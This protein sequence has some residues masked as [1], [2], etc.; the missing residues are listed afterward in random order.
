M[1]HSIIT[2]LKHAEQGCWFDFCFRNY[3][4]L[5]RHTLVLSS[6]SWA[7]KLMTW[8]LTRQ[9]SKSLVERA[10]CGVQGLQ[11]ESIWWAAVS[12][13]LL[14]SN[15]FLLQCKFP[16]CSPSFSW[17][18][19]P[20]LSTATAPITF[21]LW[22]CGKTWIRWGPKGI[23][24]S[25]SAL[26]VEQSWVSNVQ[27]S[28][29]QPTSLLFLLHEVFVLCSAPVLLERACPDTLVSWHLRYVDTASFRYWRLISWDVAST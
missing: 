26:G 10:I 15:L 11:S 17:R 8:G 6:S 13:S 9:S 23:F 29:S 16:K 5:Q 22:D 7:T 27:P 19:L 14:I 20:S 24:C 12:Q 25:S 2:D 21:V 28:G 4:A 3:K 1:E 18:S